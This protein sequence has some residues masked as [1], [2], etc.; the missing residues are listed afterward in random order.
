MRRE[1]RNMRVAGWKMRTKG[2]NNRARG[3][4]MIVQGRKWEQA[5]GT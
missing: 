5:A 2:P 4:K 1:G 3:G